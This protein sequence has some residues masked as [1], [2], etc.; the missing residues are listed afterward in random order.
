VQDKVRGRVA[1]D[2]QKW[3]RLPRSCMGVEVLLGRRKL[4]G[5]RCDRKPFRSSRK[6]AV[7]ISSPEAKALG[8]KVNSRHTVF[9][10]H[11]DH[12]L[13]AIAL[14]HLPGG[15]IATGPTGGGLLGT[16]RCRRREQAVGRGCRCRPAPRS[17]QAAVRLRR[18]L[19]WR[20]NTRLP[21]HLSLAWPTRCGRST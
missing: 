16:G 3:G 5:G 15:V 21:P 18:T 8:W 12:G 9:R 13:A 10:L 1:T 4:G 17:T 19:A 7:T 2:C 20:L 11:G 6:G 14:A